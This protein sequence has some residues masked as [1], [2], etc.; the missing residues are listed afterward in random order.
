MLQ[1]RCTAKVI[2]TL[3]LKPQ[4]LSEVSESDTVLGN[5]YINEFFLERK[6]WFIF[7]NEKTLLSFVIPGIKKSNLKHFP[8]P[9]IKG[10][11][12]LL[13]LMEFDEQTIDKVFAGYDEI[14][15]TKT[16]DKKILGNLNEITGLYKSIIQTEG[17]LSHV[18]LGA[19]IFSINQFPQRNLDWK[20][21][22]DAIKKQLLASPPSPSQMLKD[23]PDELKV[24]LPQKKT[25]NVQV[26]RSIYQIK[27]TLTGSQPPIW[28]RVLVHSSIRLS[29]FHAVIQSSMGWFDCHLHQFEK[30]GIS[31]GMQDDEFGADFGSELNDENSYKLSDLLKAEKESMNYEYDFGDGWQHKIVLEKILPFDAASKLATCIKGVRACPPEDCGGI[32][33]FQNLL[34]I[35]SNPSHPEHY[36]MLSWLDI[37]FDEKYFSLSET[38]ELLAEIT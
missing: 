4:E 20:C 2:K 26:L 38:N 32:W 31:Y 33:G 8:D 6:K 13:G 17:G 28:R 36:D 23:S 21:A 24:D 12:Q 34:E 18:D 16:A 5:W 10:L 30:E 14:Q 35:I 15:Y 11:D 29:Q 37:P 25:K 7:M 3:G 9:L 27:M 22:I 19:V 1:L